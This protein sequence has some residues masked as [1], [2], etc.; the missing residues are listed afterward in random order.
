MSGLNRAYVAYALTLVFALASVAEGYMYIQTNAR[1][2]AISNENDLLRSQYLSLNSSYAVLN[3]KY[4]NLTSQQA[5]ANAQ[6]VQISNRYNDL[7]NKYNNILQLV[8]RPIQNP[9]TPTLSELQSWLKSDDTNQLNYNAPDFVCLD[10]SVVLAEKARENHWKMGVVFVHG[11]RND[12]GEKLEHAFNLI[13]TT[14]GPV[15][16]E[17]ETDLVWWN[18]G[19]GQ[20]QLN[21][22]YQ[23]DYKPVLVQQVDILVGYA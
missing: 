22:V 6:L 5:A 21:G 13:D 11:Y 10:F 14:E 8:D 20:I 19:H 12:T 15:Y 3:E 23:I 1:I 2:N 9:L 16:V 7:L 4:S 18:A 17:P